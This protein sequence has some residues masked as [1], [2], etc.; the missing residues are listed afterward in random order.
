MACSAALPASAW[1]GGRYCRLTA[2]RRAETFGVALRHPQGPDRHRG[3][4]PRNLRGSNICNMVATMATAEALAP[5]F[6]RLLRRPRPRRSRIR[7][8]TDPVGK[9]TGLAAKQ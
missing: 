3:R 9:P 8:A 6:H 7:S 2:A 1:Y 5:L 4:E